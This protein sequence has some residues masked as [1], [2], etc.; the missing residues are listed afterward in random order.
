MLQYF[1]QRILYDFISIKVK[2]RFNN[3]I[4]VEIYLYVIWKISYGCILIPAPCDIIVLLYYKNY[5]I[6]Y[7][8]K[9]TT[10]VLGKKYCCLF[11][12]DVGNSLYS[13]IMSFIKRLRQYPW[14]ISEK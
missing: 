14:N 4:L 6:I 11:R 5:L 8:Y 9:I 3:F 13:S 10:F 2:Q 7:V 12:I 1:T